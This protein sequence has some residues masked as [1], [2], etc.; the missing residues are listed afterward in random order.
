[1]Q[2][3][4]S[5]LMFFIIITQ[6]SVGVAFAQTPNDPQ[7]V[8]QWYLPAIHAPEAW[9]KTTGSGKVVVAVIDSGVEVA[10][11]DLSDNIWHNT[12]ELPYNN[13][14]DDKNGYVDDIY[15]WDFIKNR[16]DPSPDF[17]NKD[18][19]S[20]FQHGTLIAGLIGATGNNATDGVGLNWQVKIMP[21]KALDE[22]GE[23]DPM[24]VAKAIDYAVAQKA[25]IISLSFVS[26]IGET[27]DNQFYLAIQRAHEAGIVIVAAGGNDALGISGT[28]DGDLDFSPR[29]P[30]CYDGPQGEPWWVIGVTALDK[31]DKKAPF[32]AYGFRC[33]DISAP[34]T[35]MQSTLVHN[36]NDPELNQSFGGKWS[37][38]SLAAPLVTGAVALIKSLRP[39]L[40]PKE[41]YYILTKSTD[42]IEAKN[43]NYPRQLGAGKLNLARAVEIIEELYPKPQVHS[44]EILVYKIIKS[45]KVFYTANGEKLDYDGEIKIYTRKDLPKKV[46][47]FYNTYKGKLAIA[48]GDIDGDDKDEFLTAKPAKNPV[49]VV[50]TKDGK[51]KKEIKIKGDYRGGIGILTRY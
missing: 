27:L 6:M 1:M 22:N 13:I 43:L 25:D 9:D 50:W 35:E 8:N 47:S 18:K 21:L 24:T 4:F 30:V 3:I 34:G 41:I 39:D 46:I 11:P 48:K 49:I 10:H 12:L 2:R 26:G 38:T 19:K 33:I 15:G 23:G 44:A 42:N 7:Y 37:G 40:G 28:F 32:A 36:P 5:L 51:K 31:N 14:D 45:Q 20:S 29:Y 16:P 17:K